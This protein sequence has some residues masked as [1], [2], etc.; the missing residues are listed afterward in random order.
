MVHGDTGEAPAHCVCI[1]CRRLCESAFQQDG[2]RQCNLDDIL[3]CVADVARKFGIRSAM[4][5]YIGKRLCP[6]LVFVQP[7]FGKYVRW[8]PDENILWPR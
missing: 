5:G 2:L 7:D 3:C 4:P 6:E 1:L 8:V